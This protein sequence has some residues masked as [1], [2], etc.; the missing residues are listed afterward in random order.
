MKKKS[1]GQLERQLEIAE[2]LKQGERFSVAFVDWKRET[3][4]ML[5]RMLG[6][7]SPYFTSFRKIPYQD[8]QQLY[9]YSEEHEQG[10]YNRGID[11]AKAILKGSINHIKEFGPLIETQQMK[12]DSLQI[13]DNICYRFHLVAKQ[14][15]K[16]H[17][18]SS[19]ITIKN[20]YDM[21]DLFHALLRLHFDD[22]R[23]EEPTPS[24]ANFSSRID[25]RLKKEQIII[26]LKMTRSSL[27]TKELVK[28]LAND[29]EFYRSQPDCK[30][31]VCFVYDPDERID[32]P[33]GLN[34]LEGENEAFKTIVVVAPKRH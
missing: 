1:I 18:G 23:S 22:I 4:I 33:A 16:R 9:P 7:K 28:Q 32:N 31:L 15:E 25:F 29:K 17:D 26:E 34:D 5:E 10:K 20:E 8:N 27:S 30:Y 21:Q 14:L 13:I 11:E 2:V 3:E 19:T 24:H 12:P 6:R